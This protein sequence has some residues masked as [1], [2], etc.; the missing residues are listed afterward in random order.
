MNEERRPPMA[1][2]HT[3]PAAPSPLRLAAS[4]VTTALTMLCLDLAWIGWVGQPFYA[5]LGALKRSD[6]YV[7][8]AIAF[9]AMYLT[10]TMTYA[11]TPATTPL[12]A[13]KRGGS[14]GFVCYATYE[15]TNWAVIAGWPAG[16]VPV[17][18]V[19][20]VFLTGVS[21]AAGRRVLR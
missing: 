1:E 17:D 16:L 21:A 4:V 3:R 6:P 7:P 18:I 5:T 2:S 8:A 12:A 11:V 10:A 15:L 20:G 13:L 14:L 9:Y 19:W